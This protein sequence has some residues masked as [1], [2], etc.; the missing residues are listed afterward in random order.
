MYIKRFFLVSYIVNVVISIGWLYKDVIIDWFSINIIDSNSDILFELYIPRINLRK[1]VYNIDS[2]YNDVDFNVEILE[3][4]NLN[5]NLFFLA[6]HS[7][8]GRAS[9]FDNLVRLE[10]GDFIWINGSDNN[11]VFVISEMF[12]IPKNG[13]FDANYDS[14]GNT[15]FLITCSLEYAGKQLVVKANMIY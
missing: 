11:L 7:G 3:N 9:Y 5:N 14:I 6:S 8:G 2:S 13:Y 10:V 12:Y 4:S 1:N 15:L